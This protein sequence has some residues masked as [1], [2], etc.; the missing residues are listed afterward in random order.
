MY[1][2]VSRWKSLK[3]AAGWSKKTIAPIF[4][5]TKIISNKIENKIKF[6]YSLVVNIDTVVG[7]VV[8]GHDAAPYAEV[9]QVYRAGNATHHTY[10][11]YLLLVRREGIRALLVRYLCRTIDWL[12]NQ[13]NIN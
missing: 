10:P 8:F 2:N 11:R 12:R 4:N 3:D 7:H 1:N 6:T 5:G 9:P 13:N